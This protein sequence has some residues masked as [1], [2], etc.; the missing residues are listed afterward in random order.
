ML[1]FSRRC[2]T[3]LS[4]CTIFPV[5]INGCR[6]KPVDSLLFLK[7][8]PRATIWAMGIS[9]I[10]SMD[11]NSGVA[12]GGGRGGDRPLAETLPP[13]PLKRNYTLYRGLWRVAILS[14]MSAPPCSPLNPPCC[15][16][17]LKSLATPQDF[18]ERSVKL[19]KRNCTVF[20]IYEGH[21]HEVEFS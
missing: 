19:C 13:S 9:L 14:H 21:Q 16:L 1:I 18:N 6:I 11:F 17:I 10:L 3:P 8:N 2:S 7:P 5:W 12:G 20:Q 15:P 4:I